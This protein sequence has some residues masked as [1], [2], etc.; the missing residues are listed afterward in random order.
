MGLIVPLGRWVLREACTQGVLWQQRRLAR[1]PIRPQI[2]PK[3]LDINVN[4][5]ARQL[6]HPQLVAD[7]E[8]ALRETGLDARHLVLEITESVLMD[9]VGSSGRVLES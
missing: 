7:V 8:Q 3:P 4:V 1:R 5:S 2:P 9:E 6:Q